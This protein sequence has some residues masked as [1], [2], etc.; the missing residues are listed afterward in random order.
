MALEG[1]TRCNSASLEP[2][3]LNERQPTVNQHKMTLLDRLSDSV[4]PRQKLEMT[5]TPRKLALTS[6]HYHGTSSKARALTRRRTCLQ[7]CRKP[8]LSSRISLGTSKERDLPYSTVTGRS[9]SSL[10]QSGLTYS[11]ETPSTWTTSSQT[12]TPYHTAPTTSSSLGKM[13]SYSTG[14]RFQPRLSELTETGLSPGTVQSTLPSSCSNTEGR[15]CK[16]TESTFNAT[17]RPCRP[18]FTAESSTTT[19]RFGSGQLSDETLNSRVS[20]SSLTYKFSGSL[21]PRNSLVPPA[22]ALANPPARPTSLALQI[23][24]TK[25]VQKADKALPVE[26]GT[27]TVAQTLPLAVTTYTCAR[28]APAQNMSQGTAPGAP[29]TRSERCCTSLRWER[30]PRFVREYV[31][32]DVESQR[33]TTA[34][35]TEVIPPIPGPPANELQNVNKL[36]V[37]KSQPHLFRITTPIRVDRFLDL[38]ATHPNR[39]LVESVGEGLRI[40]FWPWAVTAN[41]DL[42][43]IVDNARLQQ[44]RN[45]DHLRFMKEQRDEEI[46]LGR[47]SEAFHVLSPEMTTI[48]LWVVPKPH[49]DKLRLVADH[50]AGDYSPNSFI[51]PDDASVHLPVDTLHVLGAAPIKVKE[52]Y[53]NTKLVLFKTDL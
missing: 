44:I 15:S 22:I 32:S 13:S 50:S 8:T 19:E 10:R 16:P 41:S 27:K 14:H 7:H 33:T 28:N 2:R 1:S 49:S 26:G 39:P 12:S 17:L 20:P 47:F 36:N 43:S 25:R 48:P 38:L 11:A 4:L 35:V 24:R 51:S 30:R 3:E 46:K 40:G 9:H 45:P 34:L 23:P 53:G 29:Q 18:S 5:S 21:M 31:W 6:T 42:P 52:Q 37:I